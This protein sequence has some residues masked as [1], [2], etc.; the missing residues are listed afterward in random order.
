MEYIDFSYYLSNA[1]R[2]TLYFGGRLGLMDILIRSRSAVYVPDVLFHMNT[3][4]N[5]FNYNATE[6]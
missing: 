5:E 1:T 4:D 2:D 6:F 3:Q